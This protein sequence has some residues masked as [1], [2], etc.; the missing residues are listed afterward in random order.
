MSNCEWFQPTEIRH[1]NTQ[2]ITVIPAKAGIHLRPAGRKPLRTM[3]WPGT[4]GD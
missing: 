2:Q 1:D 4:L 3:Y